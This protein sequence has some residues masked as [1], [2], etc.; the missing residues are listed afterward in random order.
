MLS[1]LLCWKR[2]ALALSWSCLLRLE[3]PRGGRGNVEK[4]R[5]LYQLLSCDCLLVI[6]STSSTAIELEICRFLGGIFRLANLSQLSW[7]SILFCIWSFFT[8][9]AYLSNTKP[10]PLLFLVKYLRISGVDVFF[11]YSLLFPSLQNGTKDSISKLVS[12]LNAATLETD[13]GKAICLVFTYLSLPL[14]MMFTF[15]I[16]FDWYF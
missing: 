4:W 7:R 12:E 14:Y 11:F 8:S 3:R 10:Y 16:A 6:G 1:L 9:G 13:V 2:E 15:V 5:M